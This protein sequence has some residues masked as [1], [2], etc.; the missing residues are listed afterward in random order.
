M[1]KCADAAVQSHFAEMDVGGGDGDILSEQIDHSLFASA[2]EAFNYRSGCRRS[3]SD[4][5]QT[6]QDCDGNG[7]RVSDCR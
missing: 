1:K 5:V 6:P 7:R 4:S 2:K 3:P